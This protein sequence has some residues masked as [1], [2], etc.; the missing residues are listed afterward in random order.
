MTKRRRHTK[1]QPSQSRRQTRR[2]RA[3]NR[4]TYNRKGGAGACFGNGVGSN[5]YDPNYSIYNTRALQL[6]PYRGT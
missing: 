2:R 1:K 6:F 4:R 3:Y 5:H